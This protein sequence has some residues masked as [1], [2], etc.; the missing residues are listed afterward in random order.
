M[1]LKT[2]IDANK[3]VVEDFSTLPSPKDRSSRQKFNK[4]ILN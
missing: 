4:E 2:Q 1:D 3:V